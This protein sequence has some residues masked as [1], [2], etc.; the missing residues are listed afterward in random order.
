MNTCIKCRKV[1]VKYKNNQTGCN[2][3]KNYIGLSNT[4]INTR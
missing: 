1:N 3:L 4:N 2:K